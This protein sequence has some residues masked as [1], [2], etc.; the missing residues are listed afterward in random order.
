MLLKPKDALKENFIEARRVKK[1]VGQGFI[2]NRPQATAHEKHGVTIELVGCHF[3]CG[4]LFSPGS[5]SRISQ[6]DEAVL[7]FQG[8]TKCHDVWVPIPLRFL[9]EPA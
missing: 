2:T 5:N 7:N 6:P 8:N 4:G 3:P 9:I 1:R